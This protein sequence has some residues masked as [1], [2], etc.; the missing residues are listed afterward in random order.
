M[1]VTLL[2]LTALSLTLS[3]LF[4]PIVRMVAI[5]CKLVDLPD[6][7][8]KVHK[9]PIP[10]VG[11]VALAAAYFGSLLATAA[12]VAYKLPA[13]NTGFAVVWSIAPAA[14]VVFLV[15]LADDIFDL[16]P[17][18]KF[19]LQ[20]VAAGMV[21]S[22][23]IRFHAVGSFSVHPVLEI[24]GT[25]VWLVACTN[26]VNLIDGLDGLAA[27]LSLLATVTVLVA[28]LL[29]GNIGLAI[30]TA[31]LAA[32]LLGFL[33]FNFNPAS[34]FLGD[35]GSLLLGF[36]LGCYGIL[37]SRTCATNLDMGAPLM[38]LAVPLLDTTLSI[39]RRYLRRQPIFKADRSHIHHRLLARGLSHRQTVLVL[40]VAGG[41][42]GL[43]ALCLLQARANWEGVVL[44]AF[45]YAV[46][47]GIWQLSYAEFGALRRV[48]VGGG[49][50]REIAVHLAVW[51]LEE[52][53][54]TA[55]TAD[56]C[57]AAIQ[58]ACREVELDPVRMQLAGRLFRCD[59][60]RAAARSWAMR[61]PIS[62]GEWIELAHNSEPIG[63]PMAIVLFAAAMRRVLTDKSILGANVEEKT[64]VF[65]A[66]LY[67]TAAS[68]AN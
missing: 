8:R 1:L 58:G 65:S 5:R 43:L 49:L 29:S 18:H 30:A 9:K 60:D 11:G 37:W 52:G 31:P 61:I 59:R 62:E 7:K 57:W 40:Y 67:K 26:A 50:R 33:V 32:A 14:L 23:G 54:E 47:Y 25:I 6:N 4:T 41:I 66:S 34:I 16:K 22:A 63:Y 38:A 68:I 2:L 17:W 44:A 64:A 15:G 21:V 19:G 39:A 12:F 42:A 51:T 36:L 53:L 3:L 35:S 10:R 48:L 45:A 46:L 56:D 55:E 13:A 20:V 28:S 24:A 27:G